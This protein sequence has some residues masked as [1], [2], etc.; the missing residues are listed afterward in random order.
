MTSY[1]TGIML[2]AFNS[3]WFAFTVQ[4]SWLK[5]SHLRSKC[6]RYVTILIMHN[7]HAQMLTF[8]KIVSAKTR[9]ILF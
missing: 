7:T 1:Y 2:G 6:C 5:R 4:L 3:S 9:A 8:P